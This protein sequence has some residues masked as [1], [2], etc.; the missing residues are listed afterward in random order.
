MGGTRW[1][2]DDANVTDRLDDIPL[3]VTLVFC[4]AVAGF[5]LLDWL[6]RPRVSHRELILWTGLALAVVGTYTRTAW[7][8]AALMLAF[9]FLTGLAVVSWA[10]ARHRHG[11][12]AHRPS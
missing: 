5:C 9:S 6:T 4:V 8:E 3:W 7:L 11:Q 12:E 10:R 1:A 2:C